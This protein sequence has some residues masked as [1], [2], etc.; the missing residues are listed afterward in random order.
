MQAYK[1]YIYHPKYLAF[2]IEYAINKKIWQYVL[3]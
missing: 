1:H 2:L 3:L